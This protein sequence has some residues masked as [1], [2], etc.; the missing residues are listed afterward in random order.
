[1]S[2]NLKGEIM[3]VELTPKQLEY[4]YNILNKKLIRENTRLNQIEE[5]LKFDLHFDCEVDCITDIMKKRL[6]LNSLFEIKKIFEREIN[7]NGNS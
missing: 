1:M 6:E 7:K 3:K 2:G 5:G 4:I